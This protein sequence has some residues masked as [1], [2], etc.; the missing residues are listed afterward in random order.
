M[1]CSWFKPVKESPPVK[2]EVK[3]LLIGSTGN[4]KSTLGNYLLNPKLERE[5]IETAADNLPKT[6]RC[7][8]AKASFDMNTYLY[9]EDPSNEPPEETDKEPG[10]ATQEIKCIVQPITLELTVIDTPGLN[11]SKERDL[12]HNG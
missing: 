8:A 6:Q 5:T 11:E 2:Q 1:Q 7:K 3:K 12:I 4:G 9:L 10:E